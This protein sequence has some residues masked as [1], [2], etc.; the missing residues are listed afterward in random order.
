MTAWA[1]PGIEASAGTGSAVVEP[2]SAVVSA[3]VR[4]GDGCRQR[5][6]NAG[7]AWTAYTPLDGGSDPWGLRTLMSG[8][9]LDAP[10]VVAARGRWSHCLAESG[11][12][13][14]TTESDPPTSVEQALTAARSTD[15]G[16]QD[17]RLAAVQASEI[18]LAVA[19]HDCRVS[20]GLTAA[21]D[22]AQRAMEQEYVDAHR[23]ELEQLRAAIN[24]GG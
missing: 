2:G 7:S 6:E 5:A 20:S 13:G 12:P 11:H 14:M 8:A 3:A 22:A 16:G 10:E 4:A 9:V 1:Y 21:R 23:A 17:A 18:A 24:G 19:D 15:D